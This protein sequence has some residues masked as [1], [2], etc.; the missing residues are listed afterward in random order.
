MSEHQYVILDKIKLTTTI[1]TINDYFFLIRDGEDTR[2][3]WNKTGSPT[4]ESNPPLFF[5]AIRLS[6][7]QANVWV[8]DCILSKEKLMYQ[9]LEVR[10]TTLINYYE[11]KDDNFKSSPEKVIEIGEEDVTRIIHIHQLLIEH[12]KSQR[13]LRQSLNYTHTEWVFALNHYFQC[14]SSKS[15]EESIVHIIT[16]FEALLVSGSEQVSYR[17]SINASLLFSDDPSVRKETYKLIKEMY[18]LRSK[19]VHGD[20]RAFIKA[21]R[22]AEIY[23]KYFKLKQVLATILLKTY[24]VETN[25]LHEKL[26]EALFNC[27]SISVEKSERCPD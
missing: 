22:S 14:C 19:A 6:L 9:L 4:L 27:P 23:E 24:G 7:P 2:I 26:E 16:A 18:G 17:V 5:D 3:I 20:L 10:N 21:M 25:E 11:S 1:Q 8:H 15:L 12:H 13:E